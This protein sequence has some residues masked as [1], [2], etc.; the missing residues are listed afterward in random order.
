M[1][2]YIETRKAAAGNQ[3]LGHQQQPG[4]MRDRAPAYLP[5]TLK[6][7]SAAR[8][9]ACKSAIAAELANS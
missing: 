1:G 3:A 5:V 7:V 2:T 9:W 8:R 4:T 6:N